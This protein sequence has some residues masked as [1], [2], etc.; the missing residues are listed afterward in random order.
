MV[1][2][3]IKMPCKLL[4]LIDAHLSWTVRYY[5]IQLLTSV[6]SF[7][8]TCGWGGGR[9]GGR[10]VGSF[11]DLHGTQTCKRCMSAYVTVRVYV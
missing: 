1:C 4:T 8:G 11:S 2:C 9:R 5:R 3:C 6:L 7:W 10:G